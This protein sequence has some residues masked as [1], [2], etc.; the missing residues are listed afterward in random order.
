MSQ[1]VKWCFICVCVYN[2][3]IHTDTYICN[4]NKIWRSIFYL[5]V[6]YTICII[7]VISEFWKLHQICH[8]LVWLYKASIPALRDESGKLAVS[9]R[10]VCV[11]WRVFVS[12]KQ[13]NKKPQTT[14]ETQIQ[15]PNN[16][17]YN[18]NSSMI[19]WKQKILLV[20]QEIIRDGGIGCRS[21]QNT[22]CKKFQIH[23]TYT[24]KFF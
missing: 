7:Y 1:G 24:T 20:F 4:T 14:T 12:K 6:S 9:S 18:V 17:H 22:L 8:G 10:P 19:F 5:K 13:I 3:S 15:Q 16:T 21:Y 2:L 23:F 11:A